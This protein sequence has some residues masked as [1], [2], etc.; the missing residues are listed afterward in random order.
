MT[1]RLRR[2]A[3]ARAYEDK[4]GG[5]TLVTATGEPLRLANPASLC[6]WDALG[7]GAT[8]CEL[9]G[10]LGARFP[11]VPPERLRR[12]VA[13]FIERLIGLGF[14]VEHPRGGGAPAAVAPGRRARR[15]P[16]EQESSP[17]RRRTAVRR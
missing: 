17:R 8:P 7:A 12:D 3:T 6:L 16:E 2:A 10:L 4:Q 13:G 5:W 14:V 9:V 15:R 11:Q 1:T